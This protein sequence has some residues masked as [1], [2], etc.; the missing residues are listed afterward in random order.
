MIL[1]IDKLWNKFT[2][3]YN[4]RMYAVINDDPYFG[5]V[6]AE[7]DIGEI[8]WPTWGTA[9]Q[10][11]YKTNGRR[12]QWK[13]EDGSVVPIDLRDANNVSFKNA[14]FSGKVSNIVYSENVLTGGRIGAY[15]VSFTGRVTIY[16]SSPDYNV[17][18][19]PISLRISPPEQIS[20]ISYVDDSLWAPID[21]YLMLN[22]F[23]SMTGELNKNRLTGGP[24]LD[25]RFKKRL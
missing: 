16:L 15:F 21:G 2:E 11:N 24:L 10:V 13:N 17:T 22:D 18:S 4:V 23:T 1:E 6:G 20:D 5:K 3:T 12:L 19:N 8:P 7:T 14:G 25:L 9:G